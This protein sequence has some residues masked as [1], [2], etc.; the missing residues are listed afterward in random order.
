MAYVQA[1]E[2][3]GKS[4]A[5][6]NDSHVSIL[7]LATLGKLLIDFHG[8]DEKHSLLDLDAQ[9]E[10]LDNEIEDIRPLLKESAALYKKF[11]IKT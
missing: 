6:I 10:I 11:E 2:N 5:F 4:K 8:Q 7:A 9:L 3:T 1:I